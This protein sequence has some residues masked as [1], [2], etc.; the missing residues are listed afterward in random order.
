MLTESRTR[1][2]TLVLI[3]LMCIFILSSGDLFLPADRE[4]TRHYQPVKP[5]VR[6]TSLQMN[7]FRNG[8]MITAVRDAMRI[9]LVSC[10][11]NRGCDYS[12]HVG[13]NPADDP[14][15]PLL[16]LKV[17][18]DKKII[19]DYLI[20][21][22]YNL[23]RSEINSGSTMVPVTQIMTELNG[24]LRVTARFLGT[25]RSG[26][27]NEQGRCLVIFRN[28]TLP[29]TDYVFY[30]PDGG[31]RW[32]WLSQWKM[33][34]ISGN[35]QILD[36]AGS[37]RVLL[38]Q[39]DVLYQTR[40]SG[41]NWQTLFS[42]DHRK[43]KTEG[44]YGQWYDSGKPVHWH[45]NGKDQVIARMADEQ[46]NPE[47][48]ILVCFDTHNLKAESDQLIAG[49]ISEI[50]STTDGELYFVLTEKNRKR[51]S[52][53]HLK[54]KG[55]YA[56]V[57]E[58][59]YKGIFGLYAGAELLVALLHS[60]S[61]V[62]EDSGLNWHKTQPLKDDKDEEILFDK[63]RNRLFYFPVRYYGDNNANIDGL[64]YETS[65]AQ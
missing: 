19:G 35:T 2:T 39:G 52:V 29:D 16:N 3:I 9:D 31:Q 59:G 28:Y 56:S 37:G 20:K 44:S 23:R 47:N 53:N 57:L 43:K 25:L 50:D 64:E 22:T 62:S 15:I 4:R 7:S 61:R 33:P 54:C 21:Q 14:D 11:R 6:L 30:S 46:H 36:I 17:S 42:M 40:D 63:W 45:Y 10:N 55:D 65:P 24:Q 58:T 27:C 49:E 5:A 34:Q 60:D 18:P 12:K 48:D 13:F 38:V 41:Q 32:Q 8:V 51:Q 1:I 26:M